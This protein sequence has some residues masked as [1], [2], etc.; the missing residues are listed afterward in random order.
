MSSETERLRIVR[1]LLEEALRERRA[2][3][4]P[5]AVAGR[6]VSRT[7]RSVLTGGWE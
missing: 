4:S 1:L 6:A 2:Y 5:L 3:R 7:I